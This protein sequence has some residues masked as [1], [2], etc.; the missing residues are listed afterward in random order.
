MDR[1]KLTKAQ[2]WVLRRLD[3][4]GN[5]FG[6]ANPRQFG[7]GEEAARARRLAARGLVHLNRLSDTH[8]RYSLTDAGRAA[9]QAQERPNG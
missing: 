1:P 3:K 8:I 6:G 9:L 4:A 2:L 7:G 5:A